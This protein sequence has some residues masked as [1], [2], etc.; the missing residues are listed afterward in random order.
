MSSVDQSK[1]KELSNFIKQK[2]GIYYPEKRYN[3]LINKINELAKEYKY[4]NTNDFI[5]LLLLNNTSVEFSEA[6]ACKLTIGETHFFRDKEFYKALR[7]DILLKLIKKKQKYSKSI[8]IWSAG[9]SSG[10]EPYSVAITLKELI[11]EI[12]DINEWNISILATDINSKQLNKAKNGIYSEWSFRGTN[13]EFK[14]TYFDKYENHYIINDSILPFVSFSYLNL[15]VDQYPSL[16]NNTNAMDIILCRHVL[17]Y[18]DHEDIIRVSNNFYNC[19]TEDGILLTSPSESYNFLSKKLVYSHINDVSIYKKNSLHQSKQTYKIKKRESQKY[20]IRK[21]PKNIIPRKTDIRRKE[22]T[23]AKKLTREK[24][25]PLELYNEG[26]YLEAQSI[27]KSTPNYEKKESLLLLLARINANTGNLIEALKYCNESLKISKLNPLTY[28]LISNIE[29]ES[30]DLVKAYESLKKGFFLNPNYVVINFSLG[31]LAK[32]LN[33]TEEARRHL[34]NTLELLNR[35][36][37]NDIII[38]SEGILAGRLKDIVQNLLD[39]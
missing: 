2:F 26:K 18:F 7:E 19:L 24:K 11:E 8:K 25:N 21:T 9:C 29:T 15:I 31:N 33:R 23:T 1:V 14:D 20:I 39:K 30:G 12:D 28:Y 5:N 34:S 37:D 6:L 32:K 10:E 36:N 17:M 38:E 22:K 13:P 27:I 16:I 4:K 35:L 3:D